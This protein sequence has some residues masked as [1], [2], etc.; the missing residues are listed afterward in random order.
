MNR[1]PTFQYILM[2]ST[3]IV[4]KISRDLTA[5]IGRPGQGVRTAKGGVL[6]KSAL[7][8]FYKKT[9][10]RDHTAA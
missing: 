10:S 8:K 1:C 6:G 2:T 5:V 4:T 7:H 3:F 9:E